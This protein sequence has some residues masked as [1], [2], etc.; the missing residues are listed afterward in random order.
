MIILPAKIRKDLGSK[1]KALRQKEL[2]PAILYGPEIKAVPIEI[3]TKEFKKVYQEAGE[4]SLIELKGIEKKE[5]LVLIYEVKRD[6]LTLEPI[7]VDFYQPI[8]TKEVEA[9]V[10]LIFEGEAPAVKEKEGTLVKEI[11]EIEVKALPQKLPHEIRVNVECLE[12]FEDEI[13]VKDL[14]I[15]QDVTIDKDQDA[16]VAHVTAPEKVAEELEKPIEEKPDEVERV[17]KEEKEVEVPEKK[18][19]GKPEPEKKPEK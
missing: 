11:Q 7:H 5:P 19:K 14:S 8:L 10:P 13:T 3:N 18:E 9:T 17:E 4:S 15:P 2:L 12:T 1:V 6:P 16:L